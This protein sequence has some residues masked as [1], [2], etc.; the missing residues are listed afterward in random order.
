LRANSVFLGVGTIAL[1]G[2]GLLFGLTQCSSMQGPSG[3]PQASKYGSYLAGRFATG[4]RD[5]S[6]AARYYDRALKFDPDNPEILERALISE[7]AEGEIDGAAAHAEQ[8]TAKSPSARMPHLVIGI[9]AFREGGYAKAFDELSKIS[10]NAAAEIA[11]ELGKAYALL[12]EGKTDEALIA[13]HKLSAVEG[14]AAFAKYHAAIIA[15]L[16][17]RPADAEIDFAAAYKDSN[18]ESLR[19]VDAYAVH[20]QRV[21]KLQQA[22]EVLAR[23]EDKSPTHPV[24]I[25]AM[26]Q[27]KAGVMP[28]RL[29]PNASAGFAEALYGIASSLSDEKSVEI[30]VFYLQLALTLDPRHELAISLLA[31]RME[32][33]QRWEDAIAAYR[34]VPKGSPLYINARVQ[35]AQDL[36]K[37]DRTDEAIATLRET[38][39][40]ARTDFEILASIG[41]L[42]RAKERYADAVDT[43]TKALAFVTKPEERHWT[44]FYTRGIALE[45][46]KR[47][48]EAEKD[49]KFAL[50]LKH[51][52]PLVMNYLAYTWVEQGVNMDE[53]LAMLKRAVELRPEDG[54]IIDSLGWAFFKRGDFVSAIRYLE[55]A[56]LLEPGEAT[57]NDHLG[58]AYWRFGRKLEAKFE[59]QHALSLKPDKD[60]EPLIRRK[61]EIGLEGPPPG[62]AP[63]TQAQGGQRP[64]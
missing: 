46:I 12:G 30:P 58:D 17:G 59:W 39:T 50:T 26:E 5:A 47:W 16:A 10:G 61:I 44:I 45:R 22:K 28:E 18:G 52:Q 21:G 38:L 62:A 23:F 1:L 14:V 13:A 19:I 20:L 31:D 32:T 33:A 37:L 11:A 27:A 6:A 64:Q 34:R 63:A 51:E 7:V 48:S 40:G 9:K 15:D 56:V 43:Y 29:I 42:M 24:I 4:E 35:I 49:L 25:A 2:A 53:A 8:L 54:F 3:E 36:Q 55:Q 41:D 57:I 60:Q